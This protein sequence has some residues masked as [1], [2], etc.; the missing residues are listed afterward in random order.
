MQMTLIDLL[1]NYVVW[2]LTYVLRNVDM[3]GHRL[4]PGG[5]PVLGFCLIRV[6][7]SP[8]PLKQKLCMVLQP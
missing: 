2:K 8:Q 4:S 1:T 3:M 5:Q 7:R 6:T